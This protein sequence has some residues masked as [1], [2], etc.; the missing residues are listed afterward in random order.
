MIEP[1]FSHYYPDKS[2]KE[3]KLITV[4]EKVMKWMTL[5]KL[6]HQHHHKELPKQK[7]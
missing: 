6:L 3:Q 7:R 4:L 2:I 5:R 1:G